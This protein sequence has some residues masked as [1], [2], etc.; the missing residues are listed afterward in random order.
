MCPIKNISSNS[1]HYVVRPLPIILALYLIG[2]IYGKFISI[3][4]II[5]FTILVFLIIIA[6][7]SFIKQWN[8]T[9]AFLFLIIF[10]I[11]IFNYNL[12]S[13]PIGADHI[14]NFIEDKNLT[15]IGTVLEKEY[16]SN[17]EKISLKIKV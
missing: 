11:G 6:I 3:N 16:Y 8:I 5:L 1:K 14:I 9:T 12:N 15:I 2:I 7:I 10:L 4:P 17:Q 13:N